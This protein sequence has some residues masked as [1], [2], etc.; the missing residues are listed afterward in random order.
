M[1]AHQTWLRIDRHVARSSLT[2]TYSFIK[3]PDNAHYG[4]FQQA[5]QS[6]NGACMKYEGPEVLFACLHRSRVLY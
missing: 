6:K 4:L 2:L 1:S 5:G 3:L